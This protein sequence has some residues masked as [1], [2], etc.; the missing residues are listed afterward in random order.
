MVYQFSFW[1]LRLAFLIDESKE[2]RMAIYKFG[3]WKGNRNAERAEVIH[4]I[5]NKICIE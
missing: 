5:T 3:S 4:P 1:I 2:E